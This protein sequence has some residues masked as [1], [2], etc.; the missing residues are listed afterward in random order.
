ML[1]SDR[2]TDIN[3]CL[4]IPRPRS[5]VEMI[6]IRCPLLDL[7]CPCQSAPKGES[8]VDDSGLLAPRE[9][10]NKELP[11]DVELNGVSAIGAPP[12]SFRLLPYRAAPRIGRDT[13]RSWP[14]PSRAKGGNRGVMGRS[15]RRFFW[16]RQ[17]DDPRFTQD[18]AT[19]HN[20]EQH[21][22]RQERGSE[23][24]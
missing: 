5:I 14:K 15:D 23:S 2:R 9:T 11:T 13:S 10:M 7:S 6:P 17:L 12:A 4:V 24:W 18:N 19:Q 21:K 22:A 1:E 20:T 3:P 8:S 16:D